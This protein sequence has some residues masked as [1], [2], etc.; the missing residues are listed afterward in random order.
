MKAPTWRDCNLCQKSFFTNFERDHREL[1]AKAR[2]DYEDDHKQA[3][4]IFPYFS[5]TTR[6]FHTFLNVRKFESKQFSKIEQNRLLFVSTELADF[7]NF[8]HTD[9]LSVHI[10]RTGD[11]YVKKLCPISEKKNFSN[12]Y[13]TH[14]CKYFQQIFGSYRE[15]PC[16]ELAT[17]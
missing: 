5:K 10:P 8:K 15:F 4:L 12:V 17:L 2:D 14:T 1:C 6:L 7:C 3:K 11:T 16:H 13:F 9:F